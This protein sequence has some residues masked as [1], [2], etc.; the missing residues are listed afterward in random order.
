MMASL[1]QFHHHDCN[2]NVY[3][4][5]TFQTDVVLG[6][7]G[8]SVGSCQHDDSECAHHDD[9]HEYCAMHIGSAMAQ[10]H[11]ASVVPHIIS[12]EALEA[13]LIELLPFADTSG[14]SR[15]IS[16][17]SDDGY[18]APLL[19]AFSYRGPPIA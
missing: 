17:Y 19:S 1:L 4:H 5:L 12:L 15:N 7:G 8:G 6:I 10:S 16:W 11:S 2:G 9:H 18:V 14:D 13:S 3:W